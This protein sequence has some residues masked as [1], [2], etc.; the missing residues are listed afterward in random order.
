MISSYQ[1]NG[2][3]AITLANPKTGIYVAVATINFP[4]EHLEN[5]E[6]AIKDYS[7]NEGMLEFLMAHKIV[8]PPHRFVRSGYI[9]A[10]IVKLLIHN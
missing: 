10:P 1:N 3:K 6:V 9:V 4:D 7:E 2:R 8:A 5:N